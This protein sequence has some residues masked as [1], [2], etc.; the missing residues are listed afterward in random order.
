MERTWYWR[1]GLVL[2][3]LFWSL[4]QL[5]PTWA[6]FRLPPEERNGPAFEQSVPRWAPD[7]R[8]HLNLGLDLQ[9]GILL[10][11]GVDVDRAVKAKVVRRADEIAEFLKGKNVP[12][13]SA[14]PSADGWR[15][16]VRTTDPKQVEQVVQDFYGVEMSAPSGAPEGAVWFAFRPDVIKNFKEK[17][18]EQAEK[19][20][21]NRVD[22]WG[23]SEPDIKRKQNAQIQIQ[24]PGFKDPGKAKELLGRTAQL[25]FKIADDDSAVLDVLRN[26]L[27][28]CPQ[29]PDGGVAL[30]LPQAGCYFVERVDLPTGVQR[31]STY[32]AAGKRTELEAIIDR[33]IKP[34]LSR[35]QEIGIGEVTVGQGLVKERFYRTFLLRAKTEL[36]GD[37]ISDARPS[38][39][40]SKG[41]GDPVVAFTMSPEGA[42]LMEKLTTENL[43]RRMAIVLDSK[44]ESAPYIQ[45]KISSSGQITLGSGR[46]YQ[47]KFQEANDISIVLKAGALPA[48]VTIFEE[49][50]VG[51]T[52][53]PEL[54]R[55]GTIAALV[56]LGAVMLFMLLYYRM[57]GL[58]ADVAL[59]QNGLLV[60]AIMS[61]LGS[62]LTLP[63][64]AGFVLTLGMA[65]DANVLIN[66]RIREELRAGKTVRQAV[67]Q[68][69][70]KVFWT[71]VD[72][73]VTALVAAVV[74]MNYGSGPVRGFAVTLIIGL[75]ASMF[76]SI[77][78]TRVIVD[79][80]TR[81]DTARLSV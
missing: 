37:Y 1:L 36:T 38:V 59:V 32:V 42:R 31:Q 23:V 5:V 73:H 51:A 26:E 29:G 43:G 9:G 52:L 40:N 44:V 17:A 64:I 72:S 21:R 25:E 15:V 66:E 65:V 10:A 77:V 46:N 28:P 55:K 71:I 3:V 30:P 49:R 35:D 53:G 2:A 47:E 78:V 6:Y 68:G 8:K 74:L 4:W 56:G 60:L 41:A 39:D 63:G 48:P 7:A 50:T 58:I 34:R 57:S 13:T 81:N 69:Y 22:K 80:F 14:G 16:E 75:L 79:W 45:G 20:I 54:V 24:L 33:A 12:V 11:M 61:L 18:V 70:D 27:P 62:T 76:T 67:D 19:T